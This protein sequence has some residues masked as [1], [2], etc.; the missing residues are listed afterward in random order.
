VILLWGPRNDPP[1]ASVANALAA[2]RIAHLV[3]DADDHEVSLVR[4]WSPHREALIA[5]GEATLSLAQ[6]TAAYLRP[7]PVL[8]LS[9]DRQE[10]IIT[11]L[12][13]ADE[14]DAVVINPPSAMTANT[15]KPFQLQQIGAHGFAVPATLVTTDPR[16]VREFQSEHGE[17]VY[18]SVSATRS[19][20]R[21]LSPD[22]ERDLDRV[23][24]CPTQFQEYIRGDDVR[25]HVVGSS[26]HATRI[27]SSADDYRYAARQGGDVAVE[28]I[29]LPATIAAR[30]TSM[31]ASMGLCFAG[32]DLRLAHT[33]R[34]YC[35]EVNPSPGFTY[36]ER[37]ARVDLT[38]TLVDAL[39]VTAP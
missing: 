30:T 29:R 21:K 4:R 23:A 19:I 32:V 37:L 7:H 5:R 31:V 9:A 39:A 15:S 34:W 12:A 6:C 16:A 27:V 38:T 35:L 8:R 1:L 26:A 24:H 2:R 20:V 28:P 11:L 33:G 25:V 13:W 22:R 10:L 14:T 18:K 3:L 17:L 36:Y